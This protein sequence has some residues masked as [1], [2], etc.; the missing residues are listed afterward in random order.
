MT[1]YEAHIRSS[2][3]PK[4]NMTGSLSLYDSPSVKQVSDILV[5][6]GE[7]FTYDV[8][9]A[10]NRLTTKVN[11]R[12]N[13]DIVDDKVRR[14]E[15]H[16][17]LQQFDDATLVRFRRIEVKE[18]LLARPAP[19]TKASEPSQLQ[20]LQKLQTPPAKPESGPPAP[21]AATLPAKPAS[22]PEP[23]LAITEAFTLAGHKQEIWRLA[24]SPNGRYLASGSTDH[25]VC[26]WDAHRGQLLRSY[27]VHA[28]P[29]WAVTWTPDGQQL[30]TG[31][32]G[33]LRSAGFQAS[34]RRSNPATGELGDQI[35][36]F[37]G[38]VT[39]LAFSRNG[40]R[41]AMS[42][43]DG[44]IKLMSWPQKVE[45]PPER[46][47]APVW[48]VA[49]SP[50]GRRLAASGK[51]G[52]VWVW[53]AATLKEPRILAHPGGVPN[54]VFSPDG[55]YLACSCQDR[56]ARIY[57][58]TTWRE[59]HNLPASR[60]GEVTWVAYSPDG[61]YLAS[62]QWDHFIKVWDAATGMELARLP[63]HRRPVT[64]VAFSPDGKR[65]ASSSLD[66]TVKVWDV[67]AESG[68]TP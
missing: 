16:I 8:I 57:D 51:N 1:G 17:A 14:H 53:D 15:G 37:Q 18:L 67:T 39:G 44:S 4:I 7:W 59:L 68:Q 23:Q 47:G 20:P 5:K 30:L 49:F 12:T 32:L 34:V 29:I 2:P 62:A 42:S 38:R 6:P 52:N 3:N 28:S 25:E 21:A 54:V 40:S 43:D 26:L 33:T 65:L 64:C 24:F 22:E 55:K 11:G 58:A 10:G 36:T 19:E 63:G 41:L 45:L 48:S 61:K 56:T 31:A 35:A 66:F 27:S 13:M 60:A 46:L 9:A 50:D